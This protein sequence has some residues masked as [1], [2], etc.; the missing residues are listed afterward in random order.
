MTNFKFAPGDRVARLP[1][2]ENDDRWTGYVCAREYYETNEGGKHWYYVRWIK[3]CGE[4]QSE[5][6]KM[7]WWEIQKV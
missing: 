5:P 7:E 3:P 6:L 2:R 1:A 4:V